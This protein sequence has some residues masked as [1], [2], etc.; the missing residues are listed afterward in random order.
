MVQLVSLLSQQIELFLALSH[1]LLRLTEGDL[2][3][4]KLTRQ[5][6]NLEKNLRVLDVSLSPC[7]QWRCCH[8]HTPDFCLFE[9]LRILGYYFLHSVPDLRR[10]CHGVVVENLLDDASIAQ[11]SLHGVP[12]SICLVKELHH[13]SK[14]VHDWVGRDSEILDFVQILWFELSDGLSSSINLW[15]NTSEFAFNVSLPLDNDLLILCASL[16][17]LFDFCLS[18]ALLLHSNLDSLHGLVRFGLLDREQLLFL[19]GIC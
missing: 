18:F 8:R 9:T 14:D 15:L 10:D 6:F 3:V 19:I 16:L 13:G 5:R 1:T 12:R 11:E 4:L 7:R 2:Q 17:Q